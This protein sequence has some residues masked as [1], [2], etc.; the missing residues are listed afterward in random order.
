M[1]KPTRRQR[2]LPPAKPLLDER[3][4]CWTV[5]LPYIHTLRDHQGVKH[6]RA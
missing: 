2:E 1:A 6:A 4:Y 5:T 3:C